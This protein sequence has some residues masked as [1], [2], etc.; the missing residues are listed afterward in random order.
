M[1]AEVR[2]DFLRDAAGEVTGLV[3]VARDV[4]DRRT[5]EMER[6]RRLQLE[7][8][9][10]EIST[11]FISLPTES[12]DA[13]I[14][15]AL[16]AIA[17]FTGVDRS[18]IYTFSPDGATMTLEHEW[19]S[20][21]SRPL[22]GQLDHIA[23]GSIPWLTNEVK[24]GHSVQVAR[25]TDL[26]STAQGEAALFE[27][28]GVE[29]VMAVPM[30]QAGNAIGFLGL[31]SIDSGKTWDSETAT[32]LRLVAEMFSNTLERRRMD[33]ALRDSEKRYRLLAE[34]ITDVIW[35]T[36]L[37]PEITYMSPSATRLVGYSPKE[38]AGLTVVDLLT[39]D[40]LEQG[41]K[42][43][44]ERQAA[45]G[46]QPELQP[47][48][49]ILEVEMRRKDG[50]TFWAEEQVTFIR[51]DR[52]AAV[53][54]LGVTRDISQRKLMQDAL[55]MSEQK[56]RTLVEASPDGVMSIDRDGII[57]DCNP[58]LCRMLGY[59][60]D[61]LQGQQARQLM[62]PKDLAAEPEYRSRLTRG[63]VMEVDTEII[64]R[65]GLPLPV[66]VKM[67]RLAE[68][69]AAGIQTIVYLRDI[70]D[71]RKIDEMKDEFIG[72]VSHELRSPLTVI[73]GAL[74]TAISEG[75][76]LSPRETN[77]L[78]EDAAQEAEQLSHLVGNLLELSRA[79]ANRLFLHME[80]VNLAKT[81][82]KVVKSVERQ[83]PKHRFV[84][85][86]PAKLPPVSADQLRLERV[87]HNLLENS[88][89]YSPKDTEI[90][91]SARHEAGRLVVS[92]TDRGP[93]I[94]KEDQS[95]LFKPF[96][97]LGD[98]VLD[99]TKGAGLG[100]LVCRRLVEAHGGRI[101]IE[102]EPGQGATFRFTIE[103]GPAHRP[104]AG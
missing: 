20:E 37:G 73:I 42:V 25:V 19:C 97:Q 53:G 101:W 46:Q 65:D 14:H 28:Q 70:A 58:G 91:V 80:P 102:S 62:T 104:A 36:S 103:A 50:S 13:G 66:S 17:W 84:V 47:D 76:R 26:P 34:N 75:P 55:R 96:Q 15:N 31:G 52:G 21:R 1:W 43:L 88:V 48:H 33:L 85:D 83:S 35:T 79:Q 71:R 77:Q 40:S 82:H 22:K 9:I 98:P 54:L 29:A 6:E 7:V 27:S 93:G 49:W 39:P 18:Y 81:V 92:I 100:L 61:S 63:E 74:H 57:T 10:S 72:L 89:K 95:R 12:M 59:D 64:R 78:L 68:T 23:N 99:H 3:G 44:A 32:A 94:S 30:V 67:V 24:Q 86:L 2:V 69:G 45:Q 87:L 60:R 8:L 16:A 11:A 4:T 56:Y 51:D 90:T 41:M 5:A 38:L